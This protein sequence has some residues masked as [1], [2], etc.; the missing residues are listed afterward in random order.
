MLVAHMGHLYKRV[1]TDYTLFNLNDPGTTKFYVNNIDYFIS[2]FPYFKDINMLTQYFVSENT[3]FNSKFQSRIIKFLEI[4]NYDSEKASFLQ[5]KNDNLDDSEMKQSTENTQTVKVKSNLTELNGNSNNII[6]SQILDQELSS[7]EI[8]KLAHEINSMNLH[9]RKPPEVRIFK[10]QSMDRVLKK[11]VESIIN[12]PVKGSRPSSLINIK[13]DPLFPNHNPQ[14]EEFTINPTSLVMK[15]Y[16]RILGSYIGRFVITSRFLKQLIDKLEY[17]DI[18]NLL[19]NLAKKT[20]TIHIIVKNSLVINIIYKNLSTLENLIYSCS[21]FNSNHSEEDGLMGMVCDCK[22][23]ILKIFMI[24]GNNFLKQKNCHSS[25]ILDLPEHEK[26]DSLRRLV[27]NN[28]SIPIFPIAYRI[29]STICKTN[30]SVDIKEHKFYDINRF[31]LQYFRLLSFNK[32]SISDDLLSHYID[33]M[34]F[35]SHVSHFLLSLT[36][37]I[38]NTSPITLNDIGFFQKLRSWSYAI[39]LCKISTNKI[40][41]DTSNGISGSDIWIRRKDS[42]EF[43]L[44]QRGLEEYDFYKK[45]DDEEEVEN[46]RVFT[47]E[48]EE[49]YKHIQEEVLFSFLQKIYANFSD[50]IRSNY[51]SWRDFS[52]IMDFYFKLEHLRYDEDELKYLQEYEGFERYIIDCLLSSVPYSIVFNDK[53]LE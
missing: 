19:K 8:N 33:L 24:D 43:F 16:A 1:S 17:E 10:P 22:D 27:V 44:L 37:I 14:G 3:K 51:N 29:L 45:I 47:P 26:I 31:S 23:H 5:I 40:Y 2:N 28:H 6:D 35:Y 12:S 25:L 50:F 42:E 32:T 52:L 11:S 9:D 39:I 48:L 21:K 46:V 18:S 7:Q 49:R 15:S 53:K 30:G 36:K 13:Y 38:L 4:I 20:N 34:L 41:L